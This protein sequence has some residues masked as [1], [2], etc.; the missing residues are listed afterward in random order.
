MG[1][2][3]WWRAG[4]TTHR[5]PSARPHCFV[6]LD[7]PA[8]IAGQGCP[9]YAWMSLPALTEIALLSLLSTRRIP[10]SYPATIAVTSISTR[11]LG[12]TSAGI[13]ASMNVG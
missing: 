11:M 12:H 5:H 1:L 2:L 6:S 4:L 10:G 9:R 7:P 13:T 3:A 8:S